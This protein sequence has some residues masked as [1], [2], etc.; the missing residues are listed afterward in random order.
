MKKY[1]QEYSLQMM[2]RVL[3]VS[4]SG[5]YSWLSRAPSKRSTENAKLSLAIKKA[6]MDEQ[7]R[8]GAPRLA[9][10]LAEAGYMAGR[11]RIAKIM[12]QEGLRAKAAKKFKATTNSNH[13][14][15]VAPNLLLQNFEAN[16][17]NE[18]WVSDIT[19]IWTDE[20]WLYLAVVLDLYSRMVVGWA[21]FRAYDDDLS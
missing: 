6:F 16:R 17:P 7:G 5:Y 8:A 20:G 10:K 12:R 9:K 4:V 19:Y 14:L 18:K 3:S 11:H 21:H 2:A 13:R 1:R 15:P